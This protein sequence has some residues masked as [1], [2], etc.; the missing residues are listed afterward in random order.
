MRLYIISWDRIA[1]NSNKDETGAILVKVG[2]EHSFYGIYRSADVTE[3]VITV[4]FAGRGHQFY[5]QETLCSD[6]CGAR[7]IYTHGRQRGMYRQCYLEFSPS[8]IL[9]LE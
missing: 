4:R 9:K 6:L 3:K 7:I 5:P 8:Q 1:L 2:F